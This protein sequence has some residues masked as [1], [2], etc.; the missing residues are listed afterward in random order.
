[1]R[2]G[3]YRALPIVLA[4]V[5]AACS[6]DPT[7][8]NALLAPLPFLEVAVRETTITATDAQTFRKYVPMNGRYNLVGLSDGYTAYT[9]ISFYSNLF[10]WRDTVTVVSA[11]LSLRA[12]TFFGDSSGSF[13]FTVHRIERNWGQT[14][15]TWDSVQ[16]GFYD[17][18]VLRGEYHGGVGSDTE[19]VYVELDTVMAREWL[20]SV[21]PGETVNTK[22]GFILIPTPGSTVVR[23]FHSFDADTAKDRPSLRIISVNNAQTVRDTMTFILGIDT[24]T[25]NVDGLESR[26]DL[27]SAQAGVVY[28]NILNFDV[29][30]MSKGTLIS[31]AEL[32]LERDPLTSRLNR[33]SG[34][35]AIAVH[36]VIE[37]GVLDGFEALSTQGLRKA[38]TADTYVADARRAVQAWVGSA[39]YGLLIRVDGER[40]FQTFDL[41]TF[42]SPTASSAALRP[43]LKILYSVPKN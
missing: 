23:G 3:I 31:K 17:P 34:D 13:G 42:H 36:T 16:S 37:K 29:S 1:M 20:R 39:N 30:F 43:R 28:R 26:T 8:Q 14:T 11:R 7:E 25:G 15:T 18:S 27:L 2:D 9:P 41:L 35:S 40:E 22:Y 21:P 4:F 24:F 33:F 10:P 32:L 6:E 38:G 12:A 19:M 5:V